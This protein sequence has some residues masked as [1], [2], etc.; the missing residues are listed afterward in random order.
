MPASLP[1]QGRENTDS[2][3][4]C[5][6]MCVCVGPLA[7][8]Y[9]RGIVRIIFSL[10]P[11]WI[12]AITVPLKANGTPITSAPVS[13]ATVVRVIGCGAHT[14]DVSKCNTPKKTGEGVEI[15]RLK[16]RNVSFQY[17]LLQDKQVGVTIFN[18]NFTKKLLLTC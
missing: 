6:R 3:H 15:L 12:C 10:P 5:V 4:L 1:L 16:N 13:A 8:G 2:M 17:C 9:A 18:F 11:Y 7:R 14:T